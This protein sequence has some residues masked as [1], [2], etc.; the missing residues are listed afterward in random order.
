MNMLY[1]GVSL[2]EVKRD[3]STFFSD[4]ISIKVLIIWVEVITVRYVD[5]KLKPLNFIVVPSR[6]FDYTCT[7]Y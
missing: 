1:N 7:S 3:V 4:R 2:I 6:S 5:L